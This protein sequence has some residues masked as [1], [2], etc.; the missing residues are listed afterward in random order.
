MDSTVP[1]YAEQLQA[2]HKAFGA[3]LRAAIRAVRCPLGAKVLDVPC[4]DGFYTA[5]LARLLYPFGLVTAVDLNFT[6]L[7]EAKRRVARQRRLAAIEFVQADAYKL[8]FEDNTFDVVWSAR[9]LIS[10]DDPLQAL[11]E[12]KRVVRPAGTIAILEDDEFHQILFNC[13]VELEMDLQRAI[14]EVAKEKY[15]SASGLSPARFVFDLISK[16]GLKLKHRQ[17]FAADRQAPFS[18]EVK[19][20]LRIH[21]HETRKFVAEFLT[22]KS[23]KSLDSA[24]DQRDPNSLYRRTDAELTCLTTLFLATKPERQ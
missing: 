22:L 17:T 1:A 9:S 3:E 4:G 16:S 14:A 12:M 10:L 2:Y 19:D 13:S 20:Y 23:H 7:E 5:C 8:P 6:F 24:L 21:L 15:G 11:E 18:P